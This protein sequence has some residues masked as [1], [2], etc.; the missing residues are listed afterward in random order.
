MS[1]DLP[2]R[3]PVN[4]LVSFHYFAKYDI[5]EM[6]SWGLRLIGDSGAYSSMSQGAEIDI[7]EFAKWGLRWK[8][9]LAWVASLDVIGDKEAT[10]HNY[11]YLRE[12]GLEAVPTIHYG[13][14][15]SELDRYAAEG[16]DFVG[17]GGMVGRK[18][19]QARLLRWTLSVFRYARDNH[20]QMRFHGWG[21]THN[22]LIMNLPWYSVD[23]SGFSSAYR[24]GRLA[25]FDSSLGK[26]VAIV[27]DGKDIYKHV[28]LLQR[29]YGC[30]PAEV[31]V[32]NGKTRRQLVRLAV[33]SVQHT[34]DFLRKRHVVTPPTYGLNR[35]GSIDAPNAHVALGFPGAQS[36]ISLSP[37]DKAPHV[38]VV[39]NG[40]DWAFKF[41]KDDQGGN[42]HI[43]STA[44]MVL[45]DIDDDPE[46]I[47]RLRDKRDAGP[48]IHLASSVDWPF[49]MA[50]IDQK[51][52][53]ND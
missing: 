17:L 43:A 12:R 8:N 25:L 2:L 9:D 51:E 40:N 36:T 13:C 7:D 6:A 42:I 5:A 37:T 4:A 16:V 22:S 18:S 47:H 44:P 30:D 26:N 41:L 24:F 39:S 23:S 11:R 46:A 27:L 10:W 50:T 52:Q 28:D 14:D 19:E 48:N 45:A 38:H 3:K 31:A 49:K 29:E 53:T 33:A 21:I 34:E 32:S 15:P 1:K 20:P 35:G